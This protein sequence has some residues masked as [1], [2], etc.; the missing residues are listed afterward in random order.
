M[1]PT[2]GKVGTNPYEFVFN[3]PLYWIDLDGR[4]ALAGV[5]PIAGG[6]AAA[7]GPLPI[8]DAVAV[9]A[10]VAAGAWDLSQPGPNTG[11]CSR[12][13][14]GI[15]QADVA[16]AKAQVGLLGKCKDQDCCWVLKVKAA[17]WLS[18]AVARSKINTTC[19]NG[20]DA[21]HQQAAADAWQN[22][23]NCERI[24][25]TKCNE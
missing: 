10:I 7:D 1:R 18:L 23:G 19:F 3:N 21:G 5:L 25:S 12:A 24:I 14:H 16:A 8:G 20:G 17:A 13:Y 9:V 11:R 15:L 6:A 22:L 2:I 4:S